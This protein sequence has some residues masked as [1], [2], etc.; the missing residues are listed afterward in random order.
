MTMAAKRI[1][2]KGQALIEFIIF[3]PLMFA[4]YGMISG[5]ASA[6]NGSINQQKIARSYFYFRIQNSSML[7]FAAQETYERS[8]WKK[9]SIFFIGW[10]TELE[11]DKNP[12]A[13]CYKVTVPLRNAPQDSCAEKYSDD[14]T[15]FIRVGTVYGVCGATYAVDGSQYVSLVPDVSGS[16][17]DVKN[18]DSCT[19]KK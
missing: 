6:I 3:L 19:I 8:S 16:F 2:E 12:I 18:Y 5:F 4:L 13:P 17:E 10:A 9:F 7:P 11:G 1:D 15:Q 14:T